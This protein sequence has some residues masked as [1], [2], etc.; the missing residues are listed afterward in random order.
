MTVSSKQ[1]PLVPSNPLKLFG[2][3]LQKVDCYKYLGLLLTTNLS[4]SAHI[5]F[6][7]SKAKKILGLNLQEI[8]RLSRPDHSQATLPLI[9]PSTPRICLPDLGSPSFQGPEN[10]GEMLKS[11]VADLL[12]ITGMQAI[13]NYSSCLNS[14]PLSSDD[15]TSNWD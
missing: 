6:I 9:T 2:T 10:A 14:S 3:P 12:P 1:P 13:K 4:W 11:L 8:L 7:C 15:F 5:T